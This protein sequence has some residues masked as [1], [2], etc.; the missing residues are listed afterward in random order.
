MATFGHTNMEDSAGDDCNNWNEAMFS[1]F[2]C[3]TNGIATSM[4]CLTA[5]INIT[6]ALYDDSL[7]FIE[8][9][10]SID[11]ITGINTLNFNAPVNLVAGTDYYICL[12]SSG[13]LAAFDYATALGKNYKLREMVGIYP[14]WQKPL[15]VDSTVSDKEL[16]A[17][18]N[19]TE[20]DTSSQNMTIIGNATF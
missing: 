20:T 15:T 10:E 16:M 8:E 17:Y 5:E 13:G 12:T 14:S 19:Y 2:Q 11:A 4:T 18:I 9:T 7:V 3:P 1:L 6:G